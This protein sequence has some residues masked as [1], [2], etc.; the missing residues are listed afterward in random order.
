MAR[1]LTVDELIEIDLMLDE[2]AQEL[3]RKGMDGDEVF[4]ELINQ[5]QRVNDEIKSG[6]LT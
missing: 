3:L 2:V 4:E 6:D 1:K 5:A